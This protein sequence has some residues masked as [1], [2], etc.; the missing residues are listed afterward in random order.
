MFS[1]VKYL[2]MI[3]L[4]VVFGVRLEC[5]NGVLLIGLVN[6]PDEIHAEIASRSYENPSES[7]N[8]Q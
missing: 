4:S 7:K 2:E 8:M 6:L 3:L 1:T 5:F